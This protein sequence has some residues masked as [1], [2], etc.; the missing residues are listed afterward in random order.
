MPS[1]NPIDTWSKV[2]VESTD[3]KKPF[4]TAIPV[5]TLANIPPTEVIW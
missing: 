3:E 4:T 1:Q 5:A 2:G